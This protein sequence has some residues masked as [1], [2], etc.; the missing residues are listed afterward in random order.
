M[1]SFVKLCNQNKKFSRLTGVKLEEFLE[2]VKKVRPLWEKFQKSKK[3]SGRSSKLKTLEDEVL[4]L[5]MYYRFYV[6]FQFLGLLFD[7]DESNVCRH[8]HR[9]EPMLASVIKIKKNRELSQD[10]LEEI[11]IDATE[12]QIQRPKKKQK[13]FY[14]GKKKKHTIKF[15]IQTDTSG[16]ILNISKAYCGKTHDFKIRKTSEHVP[17][18]VTILA[19]SGYQGLQGIHPKTILPHKRKRKSKLSAEQKTHNRA[20]SSKRVS[21][22]HVFAHLKKFK[23]LG[24]TYR[25]FRKKLHLRFNIISGIYN[26]RFEA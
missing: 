12:I 6:S 13:E 11:L 17:K 26:L 9:L 24:S 1:L 8:I 3:V 22:E 19:D 5:L 21:V 20:L 16:K 15:E 23:I 10:C 7:L 2:I 18:D 4:M 14:S 25:N